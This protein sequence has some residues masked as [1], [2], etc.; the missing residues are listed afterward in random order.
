MFLFRFEVR[1]QGFAS[2]KFVDLFLNFVN[3]IFSFVSKNGND[4]QF[5][6]QFGKVFKERGNLIVSVL[7]YVSNVN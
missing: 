5:S 2:E 3:F 1:V 6:V 7:R 4:F